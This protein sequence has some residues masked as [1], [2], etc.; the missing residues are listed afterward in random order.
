MNVTCQLIHKEQAETTQLLKLE[1]DMDG[2]DGRCLDGGAPYTMFP[3]E[4][5]TVFAIVCGDC[6]LARSSELARNAGST[7]ADAS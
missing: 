3:R 4:F 7:Y 5:A 1:N 6:M 2:D